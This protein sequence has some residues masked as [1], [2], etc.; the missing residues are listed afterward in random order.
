MYQ[1]ETWFTHNLRQSLYEE[2]PTTDYSPQALAVEIARHKELMGDRLTLVTTNYDG[3]LERA[4]EDRGLAVKSYIQG[5]NEPADHAAVYHL[6]GRLMPGLRTGRLVLSEADYAAV[7]HPTAWQERFMTARLN[8]TLCVFV[9]VS[10]RDANLIRWLYR[11]ERTTASPKHMAL[12]VRQASPDL[13]PDVREAL[14]AATYRRWIAQG[15]E[16]VPLD[17]YGEVAQFVHE[18]TLRRA[19]S[20]TPSFHTRARALFDAAR[21]TFA[22]DDPAEFRAVQMIA[23]D[24]LRDDLLEIVTDTL[25]R[26]SIP[27]RDEMLGLGLWVVDHERGEVCLWGTSNRALA[28]PDALVPRPL[29]FRS[30]WIA[31]QAVTQGTPLEGD[32]DIYASSWRL[33]QAV[34]IV[35]EAADGARVIV[36]A[37]TLTSTYKAENSALHRLSRAARKEMHDTLSYVATA[38]FE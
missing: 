16:V 9:G 27:L 17:F 20:E 7:Q 23:V 38:L 12:F 28:T 13:A 15:V 5:R 14:E 21:T 33:I 36:G 22:I 18:V 29:T 37:L 35:A 32:P 19:D 8:E 25:A 11:T 10:L 24:A 26:E 2:R 34:P 4:L 1:R 6:H 31:V 3:L 30:R